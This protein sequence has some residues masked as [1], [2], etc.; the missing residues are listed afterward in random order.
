MYIKKWLAFFFPL[1][2]LLVFLSMENTVLVSKCFVIKL[3]PLSWLYNENLQTSLWLSVQVRLACP[4]LQLTENFWLLKAAN[5]NKATPSPLTAGPEQTKVTQSVGRAAKQDGQIIIKNIFSYVISLRSCSREK[6]Q[7]TLY[8]L[9]LQLNS[10]YHG[11]VIKLSGW[12]D[13][14]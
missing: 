13:I 11:L 12:S 2:L 3:S 4:H 6:C 10:C 7:I 8:R 14:H 5:Q 9:R 1:K